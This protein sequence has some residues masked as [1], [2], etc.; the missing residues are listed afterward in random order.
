MARGPLSKATPLSFKVPLD[1]DAGTQTFCKQAF[2]K[3]CPEACKPNW[4]DSPC[5]SHKAQPAGFGLFTGAQDKN[6]TGNCLTE[7][8]AS[9]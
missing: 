6:S 1:S 9:L 8:M 5:L 2:H 3:V 4:C 7:T